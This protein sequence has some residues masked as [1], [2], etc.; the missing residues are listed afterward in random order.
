MPDVSYRI[1]LADLR[2][3]RDELDVAIRAMAALVGEP[4]ETSP[5][6]REAS[7]PAPRAIRK[8]KGD[9]P[10]PTGAPSNLRRAAVLA[11]LKAGPASVRDVATKA[12]LKKTQANYLLGLLVKEGH[13]QRTG[14]TNNTRY[15]L[16]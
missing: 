15:T 16:A 9:T 14:Q 8:M 7:I 13:V 5:E 3:K 6:S 12:N 10:R 11:A 2:R 4:V 1:V